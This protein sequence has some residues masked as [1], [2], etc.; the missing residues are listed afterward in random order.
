MKRSIILYLCLR[1]KQTAVLA[2]PSVEGGNSNR[3]YWEENRGVRGSS[4]CE[5]EEG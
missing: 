2:C 5:R 1:Y 3:E 4:C